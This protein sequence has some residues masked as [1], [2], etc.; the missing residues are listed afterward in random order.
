M[1]R[2]TSR[3]EILYRIARISNQNDD[4]KADMMRR[5]SE[6]NASSGK[7]AGKKIGR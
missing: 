7:Q 3:T 5:K 4:A 2:N 1:L 6:S